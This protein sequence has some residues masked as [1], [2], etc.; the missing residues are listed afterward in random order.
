MDN[1]TEVFFVE[2]RRSFESFTENDYLY[3]FRIS[4]SHL[5]RQIKFSIKF[6]I[7]NLKTQESCLDAA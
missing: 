2:I 1:D 4:I 7:L 6:S 3:A 5:H